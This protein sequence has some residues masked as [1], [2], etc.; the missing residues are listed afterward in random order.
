VRQNSLIVT[1]GTCMIFFPVLLIELILHVEPNCC[2]VILWN[3]HFV[4]AFLFLAGKLLLAHHVV[5]LVILCKGRSGEVTASKHLH[6]VSHHI[7]HLSTTAVWS[8]SCIRHSTKCTTSWVDTDAHHS[9]HR[10]V[11]ALHVHLLKRVDILVDHIVYAYLWFSSRLLRS[12][13]QVV[14][15]VHGV[16]VLALLRIDVCFLIRVLDH[17]VHLNLVSDTWRWLRTLHIVDICLMNIVFA[18]TWSSRS[19]VRIDASNS[20]L[21]RGARIFFFV[22]VYSAA[23]CVILF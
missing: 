19:W 5:H 3:V 4:L 15:L 22:N 18:T 2:D 6:G 9:W 7:H 16:L 21:A 1:W 10:H 11:D 20:I 14:S 12:H 23:L 17:F 8:S 13:G